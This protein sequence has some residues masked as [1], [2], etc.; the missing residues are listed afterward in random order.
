MSEKYIPTPSE[1]RE[2]IAHL[3]INPEEQSMSER[4]E[5]IERAIK[6][7]EFWDTDNSYSDF[8]EQEIP[9]G[10]HVDDIKS[11]TKNYEMFVD[12][13]RR[14][15]EGQTLIDIGS[16]WKI[17]NLI[18]IASETGCSK[19]VGVD[20]F[21]PPSNIW[22]LGPNGDKDNRGGNAYKDGQDFMEFSP[23]EEVLRPWKEEKGLDIELQVEDGLKYLST[24]PDNSANITVNGLDDC[25]IRGES[26][27]VGSGAEYFRLL[28]EELARVAGRDHIIFGLAAWPVFSQLENV[29]LVSTT[30][31]ERSK[32]PI[33]V[34]KY[35]AETASADESIDVTVKP[36]H[37]KTPETNEAI[38][39]ED[40]LG[41]KVDKKCPQ[42]DKDAIERSL[43]KFWEF[44]PDTQNSHFSENDHRLFGSSIGLT[45]DPFKPMALI[46]GADL[47]SVLDSRS[48][49]KL[50]HPI[51]LLYG[52]PLVDDLG[53][54]WMI[55][56]L[57][58][59]YDFLK[60]EPPPPTYRRA[61]NGNDIEQQP[62]VNGFDK[63][64]PWA[65][66]TS[67][68]SLVFRLRPLILDDSG[69]E[70]FP[71]VIDLGIN[72]ILDFESK[73]KFSDPAE[74]V[75][76]P[77]PKEHIN[78]YSKRK[79][80]VQGATGDSWQIFDRDNY[81]IEYRPT[82]QPDAGS[83]LEKL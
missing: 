60:D 7:H 9:V 40:I 15:L 58:N 36:R 27:V 19:Y 67:A 31:R 35:A 73:T 79:V 4:R 57:R 34:F 5:E 63:N 11:S 80:V 33:S 69:R 14:W 12:E 30:Y 72:R 8:Y 62:E 66:A 65:I 82:W 56:H 28:A 83:R 38:S 74:Y 24:Q 20:K 71:D 64:S 6:C 21:A 29:G 44:K 25:I 52:G 13:N 18:K 22:I 1:H 48:K 59:S 68:D 10:A 2:A 50:H 61:R 39:Y 41:I 32:Y 76:Y 78:N 47:D 43:K 3:N 45:P 75:Y 26:G 54:Q 42:A 70:P 49:D 46:L 81:R 37:E 55:E 17:N 77:S 51:D 16:G 53:W 23:N